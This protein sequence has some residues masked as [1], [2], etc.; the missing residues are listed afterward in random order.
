[1]SGRKLLF[2]H[3]L[4]GTLGIAAVHNAE[5]VAAKMP[6]LKAAVPWIV[7]VVVFLVLLVLD[8]LADYFQKR[9]QRRLKEAGAIEGCWL[10]KTSRRLG[11]KIE[12]DLGTFITVTYLPE[13]QFFRVEGEVF[14]PTGEWFGHFAGHGRPD[15]QGTKLMY[16]FHGK[17]G[18]NE[19]DGTGHFL[20][21]EQRQGQATRFSGS[22]HG[23]STQTVRL[24]DGDRTEMLP[25]YLTD[26]QR[27]M[28]QG[29]KIVAYM[30]GSSTS[31]SAGAP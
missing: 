21:R 31:L 8:W 7:Y 23:A 6:T 18:F 30:S 1:M 9:G 15:P 4:L 26:D 25:K 28:E 3:A 17:H 29:R 16:D 22:F 27:R 19:D 13:S 2:V 20:F 10:E 5:S 24:V 14:T 12:Y 11:D